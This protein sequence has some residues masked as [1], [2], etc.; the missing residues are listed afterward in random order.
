[1]TPTRLAL[2][3]A[4]ISELE[5]LI[6][7]QVCDVNVQVLVHHGV[8]KEHAERVHRFIHKYMVSG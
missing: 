2:T 4:M 1:M 3:T 6:N 5:P 8:T 7:A